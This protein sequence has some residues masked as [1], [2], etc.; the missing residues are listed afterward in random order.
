MA[1]RSGARATWSSRA[2]SALLLVVLLGTG[3]CGE[4]RPTLLLLCASSLEDVVGEIL[5]PFEREHGV[6]LRVSGAASNVL[7]QQIV[8]GAPG[9][10]FLPAGRLPMERVTAAGRAAGPAVLVARNQVVLARWKGAAGKP[11]R[12]AIAD[13]GV[14]A[15]D[16]ARRCAATVGQDPSVDLVPLGSEAQ[17]VQALRRHAVDAAWI[18]ASSLHRY[19]DELEPARALPA[20]C[21]GA[22]EY[23]AVALSPVGGGGLAQALVE[24][25]AS[26]S[27]RWRAAGFEPAGGP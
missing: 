13:E 6:E 24:H 18:Y 2:T 23:R 26:A 8:A 12:V 4:E 19:R 21:G 20:H 7:A 5:L 15:G 9:D 1:S 10:V 27:A 25:L 3:G 22:V 14:P 17:V 16:H 11:A